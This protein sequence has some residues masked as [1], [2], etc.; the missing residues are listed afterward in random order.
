MAESK[1]DNSTKEVAI[2]RR[3]LGGEAPIVINEIT[4]RC[5][6]SGFFGTLDSVRMKKVNDA[7]ME[8]ADRNDHDMMIIDLSNVEVIDSAVAN[9]LKKLNKL[10]QL[11]GV[12]V[13][14]C[15]FKPIVASS[16]ISAGIELENIQVEKNLKRAIKYVYKRQGLKLVSISKP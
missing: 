3:V 6:Y 11:I 8:V 13:V 14:F 10:L 7:I 1:K 16:M 2:S 5:L 4:D 12:E 9:N 15:G